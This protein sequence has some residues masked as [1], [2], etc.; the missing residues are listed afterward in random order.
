[1]KNLLKA[2][3]AAQWLL[4]IFLFSR[5]EYAWWVYPA[6]ILVPDFSMVGYAFNSR[7]GALTYNFFH[8]KA[9]G[10]VVGTLGLLL[11]HPAL[12][13]SGIILFGHSALDRMLGY[14]LKYPSDFK[15][16]HLGNVGK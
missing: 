5:L 1:M 9:L 7:L 3:E 16:T 12:M 14:G 11:G 6:L 13:L 4:S 2:E 10:I 15:H 8:H